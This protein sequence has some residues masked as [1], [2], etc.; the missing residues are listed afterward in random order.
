MQIGVDLGIT[1]WG[2]FSPVCITIAAELSI[3]NM[4]KR[5]TN[6]WKITLGNDKNF[7]MM[8]TMFRHVCLFV[9]SFVVISGIFCVVFAANLP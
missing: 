4:G 2:T 9:C 7:K 1:N 3:T 8:M 6:W 5:I